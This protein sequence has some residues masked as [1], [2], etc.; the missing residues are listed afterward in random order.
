M[1]AAGTAVLAFLFRPVWDTLV[2]SWIMGKLGG[3]G[4]TEA[5]VIEAFGAIGAP[6][7]GAIAVAV[8]LHWYV[9]R[10]FERRFREAVAPKLKCSFRIDDPGC[11]RPKTEIRRRNAPPSA[12]LFEPPMVYFPPETTTVRTVIGRGFYSVSEPAMSV[13]YYRVKVEADSIECVR[14]CFGRLI[15]ITKEGTVIFS[16]EPIL[17]PFAP[18]EQPNAIRKDVFQV[19]PEFLDFLYI[20]DSDKAT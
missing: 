17:L 3:F 14:N 11:V 12:P 13:T 8:F 5:Q 10:D 1:L 16:G 2:Y 18:A 19:A 9:K 6:V 20:T 15:E 4:L 7:L